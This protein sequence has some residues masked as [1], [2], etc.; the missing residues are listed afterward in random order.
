[1]GQKVAISER[2]GRPAKRHS[3]ARTCRRLHARLRTHIRQAALEIIQIAR[4]RICLCCQPALRGVGGHG[5]GWET[6]ICAL[7]CTVLRVQWHR[8]CNT[9]SPV[10]T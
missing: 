6:L 8:E 2:E 5:A 10:T 4:V 7:L 1:M 9:K 3:I